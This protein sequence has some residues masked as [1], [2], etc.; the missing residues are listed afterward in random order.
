MWL[1]VGQLMLLPWFWLR[2]DQQTLGVQ[3]HV[4]YNVCSEVSTVFSVSIL[5]GIHDTAYYVK[6]A[7]PLQNP[8]PVYHNRPE[9]LLACMCSIMHLCISLL[10][11]SSPVLIRAPPPLSLSLFLSLSLSCTHTRAK[12]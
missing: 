1:L 6:V 3:F 12:Y 5:I 8:Q 9:E 11:S 10:S 7:F 4:S 2:Y